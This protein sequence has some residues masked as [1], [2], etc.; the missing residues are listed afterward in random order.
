MLICPPDYC[1]E[2]GQGYKRTKKNGVEF[3]LCNVGGTGGITA[4]KT[5][6]Q[7]PQTGRD[8]AWTSFVEEQ[9]EMIDFWDSL[10]KPV[11]VLTW[12]LLYAESIPANVK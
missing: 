8:D 2:Y 6:S 7:N 10:G 11:F 4:N 3:V 9:K 5:A 1:Q 12:D